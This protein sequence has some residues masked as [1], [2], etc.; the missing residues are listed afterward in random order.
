VFND[1][2]LPRL[3]G[4]LPLGDP[5]AMADY[6]YFDKSAAPTP[7]SLVCLIVWARPGTCVELTWSRDSPY[8]AAG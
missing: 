7:V 5:A 1:G 6:F 2:W 3:G 8:R 4:R